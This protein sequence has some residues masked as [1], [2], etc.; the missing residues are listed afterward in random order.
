VPYREIFTSF[1]LDQKGD[2]KQSL[3]IGI[4]LSILVVIVL[5]FAFGPKHTLLI[6]D[7]AWSIGTVLFIR[8][9]RKAKKDNETWVMTLSKK[10][11]ILTNTPKKIYSYH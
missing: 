7:I 9:T 1:Y 5:F 8:K 2:F 4:V 10:L 11:T 6:P 3:R